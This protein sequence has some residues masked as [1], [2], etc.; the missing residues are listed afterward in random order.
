MFSLVSVLNVVTYR[1]FISCSKLAL[2]K[3]LTVQQAISE[4]I[5]E[6][7]SYS[8]SIVI[9][10]DLDNIISFSSDEG[11]RPSSSATA[12]VNYVIDIVDEYGVSFDLWSNYLTEQFNCCF[13]SK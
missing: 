11:S 10:D 13:K 5:S 8:P 9:F 12:L 2:E 4:Y 1:I 7:L 3:S 6:A